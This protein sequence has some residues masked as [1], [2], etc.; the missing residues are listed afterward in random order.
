[1]PIKLRHRLSVLNDAATKRVVKQFSAK[2]GL[3]YFGHV[4][5]QEDDHQLVRGLTVSTTHIDNHYTVGTVQGHDLILVQRRNTIHF[6]GKPPVAHKWLIL[7]IDLERQHLP[8]I[9]LDAHHHSETFYAELFV[10]VP[11]FEEMHEHFAHA[12]PQFASKY[13]VFTLPNQLPEAMHVLQP[14]LTAVI[15]Q[16]FNQFNFEVIDDRLYVYANPN[17][18]TLALLQEMLRAGVW[19]ADALNGKQQG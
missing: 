12:D 6:P 16:Y 13:K 5:A 19:F 7:E 9:F 3:V 4:D 10:K 14:A 2:F 15:L 18:V 8:H 17:V 1:M 11:H